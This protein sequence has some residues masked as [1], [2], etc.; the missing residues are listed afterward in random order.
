[1][2]ITSSF[3]S[4]NMATKIY[5]YFFIS[6]LLFT[7]CW[8]NSD[9]C[10]VQKRVTFDLEIKGLSDTLSV[11]DTLFY[12]MVI[13]H[14]LKNEATGELLDV[15]TWNPFPYLACFEVKNDS[16]EESSLSFEYGPSFFINE[17]SV[18]LVLQGAAEFN[19]FDGFIVLL[20]EGKYVFTMS[21]A[22]T[23]LIFPE[24]PNKFV[25]I[26][27]SL[28]NEELDGNYF[29]VETEWKNSGGTKEGAKKFGTIA[30]V[31]QP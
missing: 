10:D 18:L 30:F 26:S 27:Y 5:F 13:P 7:A 2:L 11:G 12:H 4:M 21:H 19:Y 8:K 15:S 1:M 14:K 3:Y 23:D 6:F 9:E 22:I 16:L 29:L 20:K 28:N 24:C 17:F 31:V 25:N